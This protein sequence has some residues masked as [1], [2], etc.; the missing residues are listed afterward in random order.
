MAVGGRE[1][2]CGSPSCYLALLHIRQSDVEK[3]STASEERTLKPGDIGQAGRGQRG[4]GYWRHG[5]SFP[6]VCSPLSS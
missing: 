1:G 6:G 2:P 4:G 5:F 3:R